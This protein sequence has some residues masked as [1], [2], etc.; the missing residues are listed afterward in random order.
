MG[1]ASANLRDYLTDAASDK[2]APGGG[3]VSA[4]AGALAAS[5]GEMASNFTV[6]KKK[7]RDVEQEVTACLRELHSNREKLLALLD[8][9]VE[10]Y[11]ALSRAYG[12]SKGSEQ[13]KAARAGAVQKALHQALEVPL[14]VMRACGSVAETAARLVRIANPNLLTDVG[15]S[16]ILA[17]A[18]CAAAR[19][20]VEVNLKYIKDRRVAEEVRPE[21]EELTRKTVRRREEVARAVQDY[22]SQ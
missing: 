12:M 13:E 8:A 1:Y 15:V 17:E 16:A 7:F 14:N 19:L 2:P 10:A 18:A 3:S 6:G 21:A 11:G 9:D 20:N 4:L 5:M 22:L